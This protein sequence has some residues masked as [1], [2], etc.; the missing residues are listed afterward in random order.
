[1]I[2]KTYCKRALFPSSYKTLNFEDAHTF[3]YGNFVKNKWISEIK[4]KDK[5]NYPN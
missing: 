5:K 3:Y 1:M 2:E 4:E